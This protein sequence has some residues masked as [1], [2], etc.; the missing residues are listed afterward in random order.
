MPEG[1]LRVNKTTRQL[2]FY[3]VTEMGDITGEYIPKTKIDMIKQLAQKD[4]NKQFLKTART[5]LG[6]GKDW[7]E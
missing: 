2:R 3:K 5:E 7:Y 4:Y 1:R 6:R